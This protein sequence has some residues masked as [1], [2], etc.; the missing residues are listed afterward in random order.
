MKDS[1]RHTA[2]KKD[3]IWID[4]SSS[5]FKNKY[6]KKPIFGEKYEGKA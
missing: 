1:L 5:K 2:L 4:E 6:M 3:I